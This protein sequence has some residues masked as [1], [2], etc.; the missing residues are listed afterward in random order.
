M[1]AP[2]DSADVVIIGGGLIGTSAAYHLTKA[3]IGDIL[4][5]ERNEIASGASARSAGCFNHTRSD[6]ST[7]RMISRTRKA[8]GELETLLGESIDFHNDGSVRAVFS[9][10]RRQEML[11]MEEVMRSAGIAV[12]E[13]DRK[14]A[15][16][17]VPWLNVD[18]AMRAIFVPEDGYADGALLATA[19][20]RAARM[21]G[22][23]VKR[24]V[25]VTGLVETD[26]EVRGVMTAAGFIRARWVICAAGVWG[27]AM[28]ST[29]NFGFAGAPT[30]S[31]YWIT[32]PDG[33]GAK[34]QPNVQL[35]DMRAYLRPEVGGLLVGIQEPESRTY[36][37]MQLEGDMGHMNLLDD[38]YDLDLLF[39]Q[40]SALRPVVP[41]IDNWGFAHHIAGL[42]MY[43]PDGK[44][45][46]GQPEGFSGVVIAGGCCGSGLA[47]SG[48]FGEVIANIVAGL[49]TEIDPMLYNPNRFGPVDPSSQAFRDRCA[50]ARSG[51]SRGNLALQH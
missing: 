25:E 50:A 40:A 11:A 7:I 15:N 23:R 20:S 18:A 1:Q 47:A 36:H 19:Y 21:A 45:V 30:R 35:P 3:G 32:A 48:G 42:S 26:G 39:E 49:P 16:E 37:P 27:A 17:R 4:V 2:I 8:I 31:H 10:P 13:I 38:E 46:L 44:F 5:L 33:T 28:A 12:R 24:G 22:T 6:A 34:G 14:E 51:K 43:T 41:S 9:E 29:L